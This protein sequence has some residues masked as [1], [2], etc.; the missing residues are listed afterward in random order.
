[1]VDERDVRLVL[2]ELGLQPVNR[3]VAVGVQH[4]V[5]MLA[6][7]GGGIVDD[8][9]LTRGQALVGELAGVDACNL[10]QDPVHQCLR[11]LL[12]REVVDLVPLREPG[13]QIQREIRLAARGPPGHN[14]DALPTKDT[15][16]VQLRP[17]QFQAVVRLI[18]PGQRGI[19]HRV[20]VPGRAVGLGAADGILHRQ[21]AAQLAADAV[22]VHGILGHALHQVALQKRVAVVL[23]NLRRIAADVGD[24]GAGLGHCHNAG[25][26]LIRRAARRCPVDDRD[27]VH[28]LPGH[29]ELLHRAEH[30]AAH[31]PVEHPG[32]QLDDVLP[33]AGRVHE[34]RAQE[35]PLRLL[36]SAYSCTFHSK[37]SQKIKYVGVRPDLPRAILRAGG[38]L[39]GDGIHK[40]V[41]QGEQ[42]L[43]SAQ[44]ALLEHGGHVAV[45]V[46]HARLV[47]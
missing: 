36:L 9:P 42:S 3:Q 25:P 17:S 32:H 26:D 39:G 40:I 38:A 16:P 21:R 7:P 4:H 30:R 46:T 35:R 31:A 5:V 41:L 18:Q 44:D 8:L 13:R 47:G 22:A 28:R 45:A 27:D 15:V 20:K 1:M 37:A 6:Q 24:A 29:G 19:Q 12:Q 34:C 33:C 10:G 11:R 14:A 23:Q 2:H 43:P